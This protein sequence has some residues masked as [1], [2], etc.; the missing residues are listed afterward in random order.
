MLMVCLAGSGCSVGD[1]TP[2]TFPINDDFSGD[3]RWPSGDNV[4]FA[5]GCHDGT[6]RLSLKTRGFQAYHSDLDYGL[7]A[8]GVHAEVDARV[9]S[10]RAA[11]YG[12]AILGIGCLSDRQ[13]GY[14]GAVGT[15]GTWGIA[16][17]NHDLTW[18]AGSN[19]PEAIDATDHPHL[20]IVCSERRGQPVVV[21]L[22]VD[23]SHV[24]ST[25][26]DRN[27]APFSGF[28]LWTG[29]Y[30]GVVGFDR[31][32][33]SRPKRSELDSGL[34]DA[35]TSLMLLNEDFTHP[36]GGWPVERGAHGSA[37]FWH[38]QYRVVSRT[39]PAWWL[40]R[41][42]PQS[43]EA[44]TI[45]TT[46]WQAS[47]SDK[48]AFGVTCHD[49]DNIGYGFQVSRTGGYDIFADLR[50]STP[51]MI[52][53][54]MSLVE[55]DRPLRITGSCIDQGDATLLV[56]EVNGVMV[57]R[58]RD[59]GGGVAPFTSVGL[60]SNSPPGGDVRFDDFSAVTLLRHQVTALR[61]APY[62]GTFVEIPPG[63]QVPVPHTAN[64]LFR[65]D[66]GQNLGIWP[67]HGG[68]SSRVALHDGRLW[69]TV[70]DV[71]GLENPT[72]RLSEPSA[73]VVIDA[74]LVERSSRLGA[75]IGCRSA[76]GNLVFRFVVTS[77]TGR[78]AIWADHG[79]TGDEIDSGVSPYI[80]AT[81]SNHVRAVCGAG[82]T[83]VSLRVN[84]HLLAQVYGG[85][86]PG[87]YTDLALWVEAGK[88]DAEVAF[89]NLTVRPATDADLTS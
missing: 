12:E 32:A 35:S 73:A 76:N 48:S 86:H 51:D 17:L 25:L 37:G 63:P 55:P 31:F 78:Y 74:D 61:D 79:G 33:A 16:R 58:V 18:I 34:R 14:I 22:L 36:G 81:G 24:G 54:V 13:H 38:G 84:G 87:Q 83:P 62:P 47:G 69:I 15:D 45:E 7:A 88:H 72:T 26:D 9:I 42:L 44:V 60:L 80:H 19:H 46:A 56:L 57:A 77:A 66:F 8:P 67:L 27:S 49:A 10:G 43:A 23:G 50:T 28:S 3:C 59:A 29:A 39:R 71:N 40:N 30:P 52:S 64:T 5:T 20:G 4:H 68:K 82:G 70:M 11:E 6:Y 2:V 53:G 75:G 21:S 41:H 65:D 85:L 1:A 89:D